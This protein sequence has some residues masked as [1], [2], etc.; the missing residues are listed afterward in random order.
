MTGPTFLL[1]DG[2]GIGPEIVSATLSVLE[3]ANDRYSLDLR[4]ALDLFAHV[5]GN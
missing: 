5:R 3:T 2:D 1:I 4:R